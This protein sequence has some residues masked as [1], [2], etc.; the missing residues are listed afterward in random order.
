M[1]IVILHTHKYIY[2]Y[3][4]LD[5]A[6]GIKT[7]LKTRSKVSQTDRAD[8]ALKIVQGESFPLVSRRRS[9][10]EREK[11]EGGGGKTTVAMAVA[12]WLSGVSPAGKRRNAK[13]GALAHN[14]W[15]GRRL[16]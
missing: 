7:S 8:R 3:I 13:I 1:Y 12:R 9:G 6:F 15:R 5:A 16:S 4:I 2:I 10:R 14:R 11:G